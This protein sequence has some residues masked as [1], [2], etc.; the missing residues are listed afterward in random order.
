MTIDLEQIGREINNIPSLPVVVTDVISNLDSNKTDFDE[1]EQ[2]ISQDPAMTARLLAVANSSFYGLSGHVYGV[3]E[4][5]LVLGT[6]TIRSI[7]I[8]IGVMQHLDGNEDGGLNH[9]AFWR[10]S[11]GAAVA[12][13][14]LA[15]HVG[16]DQEV[17]FTVGLLHDIGELVLDSRFSEK[18]AE[19]IR[20]YEENDCSKCEA[21]ESVLGFD[22]CLVG[23][24][25]A[26]RWRL[27]Q[28]IIDS[29]G[30]HHVC[31]LK[32]SSSMVDLIHI[33]D[34]V[35]KGMEAAFEGDA[36]I[37]GLDHDAMARLGL[38]M[39]M[40]NDSLDEIGRSASEFDALLG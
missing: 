21:E 34:A 4:A 12:A 31:N 23:I 27:P 6:N 39:S 18:Y 16:V 35:C 33:V 19:V 37:P 22:H 40:I 15:K 20:Y 36:D 8:A 38:D 32:S 28:V 10:H 29:I 25:L 3:K 7:V 14:V 1:L 26:E 30:S 13:R 24:R 5:C 9:K 11:I 2:K 17:A